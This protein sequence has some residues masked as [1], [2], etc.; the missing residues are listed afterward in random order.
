MPA[1]SL[2]LE[3]RLEGCA[4]PRQR[5]AKADQILNKLRQ[6]FNVSVAELNRDAPG[7]IAALAFATVAR[8]RREARDLLDRVSEA[9]AAHPHAEI[10]KV[11]FD[12]I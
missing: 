3:V 8:T 2:I 7:E 1:V 5:H 4:S 9:V 6:H 11:A 10:I 12:D